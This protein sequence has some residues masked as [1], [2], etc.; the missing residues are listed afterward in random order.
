[1][2]GPTFRDRYVH[3]SLVNYR[4]RKCAPRFENF[5]AKPEFFVVAPLHIFFFGCAKMTSNFGYFHFWYFLRVL[6][7]SYVWIY[8]TAFCDFFWIFWKYFCFA[9]FA[10]SEIC[11]TRFFLRNDRFAFLARSMSKP[12]LHKSRRQAINERSDLFSNCKFCAVTLSAKSKN[13]AE[14]VSAFLIT[15]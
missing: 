6:R 14:S 9:I 10:F 8:E 5:F 13:G 4:R 12:I 15:I 2:L 1:M 7:S 3:F 11:G